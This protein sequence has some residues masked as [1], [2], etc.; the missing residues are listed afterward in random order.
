MHKAG[1]RNAKHIDQ[2]T[3]TLTT[4]AGPIFGSLPVQAV[5]VGLLMKALEPIWTTKPETASRL[6]GRIEA[7]LDWSTVRGYRKGDNP[8]RWRGHLDKLLPPRSKVRKVE[9]HAAL[10]YVEIADF[11]TALRSQDGIAA[12]ALEFLIVTATRTGEVIGARWDEVDL[13]EKTWIVPAARMKARR[14]HRVPLSTVALALL[15]RMNEGREGNFVF[16]GGKEGKP[17]SNMAMLADSQANRSRRPH[18]AWVSLQFSRLGSRTH[19]LPRRS[20]GNGVGAC[21]RRQG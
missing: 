6:R 13:E 16:P 14:E 10:P 20:R 21:R 9:H 8:A 17:L 2:W 4:Y 11:V 12:R 1:W 15:K 5:D 19:R 18:R 3:N 7:V